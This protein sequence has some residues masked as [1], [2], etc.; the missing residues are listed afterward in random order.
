MALS[1][2]VFVVDDDFSARNGFTRLLRT[3]GYNVWSFASA[4]EFLGALEPWMHSCIVLD[5]RMSGMS[6][7]E[8]HSELQK[9]DVRLHVIVV[10]ADDDAEMRSQ[11]KRIDAEAFF[12]KPVDAKALLDVIEWAM[13]SE[14]NH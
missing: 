13:H 7:E 4:D 5:A 11:A 9:R 2:T 3:A 12:R 1:D 6:M 14:N 8:L 10:T